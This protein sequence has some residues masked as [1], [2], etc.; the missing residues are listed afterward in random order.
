MDTETMLEALE[1]LTTAGY[2]DDFRAEPNGLRARIAGN[3]HRPE[4]LIIE[5]FVRF[6]GE[7]DPSEEAI[8]FALR[9]EKDMTR[10]TYTVAYGPGMD[11]ADVEMVNRLKT[12]KTK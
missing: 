8:V 9:S 1:R 10:G 6:E 11:L 5:E 2:C 4:S 7:T 3:L 12:K